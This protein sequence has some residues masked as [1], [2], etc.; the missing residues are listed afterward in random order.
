MTLQNIVSAREEKAAERLAD[1]RSQLTAAAG[2]AGDAFFSAYFDQLEPD[3]ILA[4]PADGLV[5][6]A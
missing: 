1:V 3:D 5:G 6:A 2:A 4:R